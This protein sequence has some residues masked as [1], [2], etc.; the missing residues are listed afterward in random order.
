[1]KDKIDLAR[2]GGLTG[3]LRRRKG[4]DYVR[5]SNGYDALV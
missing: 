5:R 4:N 1:M 3:L 2:P